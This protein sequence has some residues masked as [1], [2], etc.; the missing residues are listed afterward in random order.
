MQGYLSSFLLL[1]VRPT[2]GRDKLMT[3]GK[4]KRIAFFDVD[5]TLV[6]CNSGYYTSLRLVKHKILKKRRILQAI[7]YT[8]L[9]QFWR[10]DIKK[11]YQIA[12]DDM[13]G[14]TIHEIKEIG[15]ECFENDIKHKIFQEGLDKLREHQKQGDHIVFL[16]AGPYMTIRNLQDFLKI[17]EAYTMGPEIVNGI[18]TEKLRIPICH[19]E[20][21]VHF[22]KY[23]AEKHSVSLSDCYF[24]TDH[25]TDLPLLELVGKPQVVN[26]NRQLKKIAAERDWPIHHFS[27][28]GL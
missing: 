19:G 6:A 25:I 20:G 8:I 24:Y 12:I 9:G 26:P 22:A 11:I 3:H 28:K 7:Y 18:L 15:R 2:F 21:K 4:Q 14:S 16:T 23:A 13:A 27:K 17:E 1:R 10:V 5:N